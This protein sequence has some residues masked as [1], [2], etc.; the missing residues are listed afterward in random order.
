MTF[1]TLRP[2]KSED[3]VNCDAVSVT[4]N[5]G[6]AIVQRQQERNVGTCKTVIF[7]QQRHDCT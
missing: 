2:H 3:R 4:S 5:T 6:V 7:Q 1:F